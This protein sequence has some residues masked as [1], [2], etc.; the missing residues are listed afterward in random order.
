MKKLLLAPLLLL[1]LC[2]CQSLTP[3]QDAAL[4]CLGTTAGSAIAASTLK[5]GTAAAVATN[6][7]VLCTTAT[8]V[9]SIVSAK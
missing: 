9:A 5:P 6:G 8:G 2:G 3:A 1:P 4:A 7:Q